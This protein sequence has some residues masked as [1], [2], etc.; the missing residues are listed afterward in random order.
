M[1]VDGYLVITPNGEKIDTRP[2]HHEE[3]E[4]YTL[5]NEV[6]EFAEGGPLVRAY[7]SNKKYDRKELDEAIQYALDR[8]VEREIAKKKKE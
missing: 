5:Y 4:G 8:I 3:I 6:N 7:I 1:I 2:G